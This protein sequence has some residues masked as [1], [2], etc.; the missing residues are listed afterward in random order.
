MMILNFKKMLVSMEKDHYCSMTVQ[1][2]VCFE[3][4]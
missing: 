2:F 4:M 1:I 3:P